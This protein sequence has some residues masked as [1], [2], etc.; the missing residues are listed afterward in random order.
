MKTEDQIR[1]RIAQIEG[2]LKLGASY[3]GPDPNPVGTGGLKV[4]RAALLWV[5]QAD[6]SF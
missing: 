6:S 3:G 4:E 2:E 5:L 1:R